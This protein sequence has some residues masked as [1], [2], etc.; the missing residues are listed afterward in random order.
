MIGNPKLALFSQGHG[1]HLFWPNVTIDIEKNHANKSTGSYLH[2][3]E[4]KK[5]DG[6][7]YI[8][9]VA[10]FPFGSIRRETELKIK[11]EETKGKYS[12]SR[13]CTPQTNS[14]VLAGFNV[15]IRLATFH[16]IVNCIYFMLLLIA[17]EL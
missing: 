8:C 11:G 5:W 9:D 12:Q 17:S 2:L 13:T 3:L 7:I 10:T 4:V 16:L 6:G 1:V 15:W 14:A